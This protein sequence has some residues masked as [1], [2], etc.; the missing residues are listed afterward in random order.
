[1]CTP[2][3]VSMDHLLDPNDTVQRLDFPHVNV[4]T[5]FHSTIIAKIYEKVFFLCRLQI[6]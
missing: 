6:L 4:T 5:V 2:A 3:A 1:M